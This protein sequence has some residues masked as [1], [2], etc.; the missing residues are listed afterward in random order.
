VRGKCLIDVDYGPDPWEVDEAPE[1]V[2]A[3]VESAK[4]ANRVLVEL[5]EDQTS[6]RRIWLAVEAI[7]AVYVPEDEDDA[8][9]ARNRG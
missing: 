3:K 7:M 1:S 9:N 2:V 5:I 6:G 8:S 4:Q